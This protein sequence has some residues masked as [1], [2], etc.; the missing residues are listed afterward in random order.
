M[1]FEEYAETYVSSLRLIF[2]QIYHHRHHQVPRY[3]ALGLDPHA[4]VEDAFK[5]NWSKEEGP[6]ANPPWPLIGKVL[7]KVAQ[8]RL[9]IM[10]LYHSGRKPRG[11]IFY[12]SSV[13][14][15]LYLRM[16]SS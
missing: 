4:V 16:Q 3:F 1:Y 6:Y 11:L 10:I 12:A 8:E 13:R 2:L 9:R 15:M 7:K 14:N 5:Q